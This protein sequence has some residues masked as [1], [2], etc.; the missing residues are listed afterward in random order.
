MFGSIDEYENWL[1][2]LAERLTGEPDECAHRKKKKNT[3]LAWRVAISLE[4]L[5]ILKKV[6]RRSKEETSQ[7][8]NIFD[9]KL[10]TSFQITAT[11]AFL[12]IPKKENARNI[13]K[14]QNKFPQE[15]IRQS[16]PQH[17]SL[18]RKSNTKRNSEACSRKKNDVQ[19]RIPC[20]EIQFISHKLF[21]IYSSIYNTIRVRCTWT[22]LQVA[23]TLHPHVVAS[24]QHESCHDEQDTFSNRR[25]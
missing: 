5:R 18:G 2:I 4:S 22:W 3:V 14:I 16:T 12:A 6:C 25:G 15:N 10:C 17:D 13:N 21:W 1:N 11:L 7:R 24:I 19:M 8:M 9:F 20:H 23:H